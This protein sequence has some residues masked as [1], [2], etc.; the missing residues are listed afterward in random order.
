MGLGVVIV[1]LDRQD[2]LRECLLRL[3]EQKLDLQD[4]VVVDS[5]TS[6]SSAGVVSDF[7]DVRYLCH[8][9]GYG[10]MTF[11]RNLGWRGLNTDIVAFIDDD[12]LVEP[13]WARQLIAHYADASVGAVGGRA[14]NGRTGRSD[15]TGGPIGRLHSNGYLSGNFDGDPGGS[16]EVDHLIGCNM[17]FRR[18]VL[19]KLDGFYERFPGTALR[20]ETDFCLRVKEAGFRLVFAPTAVV[21]HVGAPHVRGRRFDRRYKFFAHR[22]HAAMLVAHYSFKPITLRFVWSEAIGSVRSVGGALERTVI[23]ALAIPIGLF[24]GWRRRRLGVRQ[25]STR[26]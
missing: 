8:R 22:N 7:P 15:Y 14:L 21:T 6:A 20:E 18:E 16:V 3:S 5:S 25:S 26:T 11:S 1:T 23:A 12:S 4:I 2:M 17:S 9:Q 13:G 19:T 10:F 24:S